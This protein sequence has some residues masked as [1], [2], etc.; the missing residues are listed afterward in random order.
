MNDT[1]I[2]KL[3]VL[4]NLRMKILPAISTEGKTV[5]DIDDLVSEVH[6]VMSEHVELI[7]NE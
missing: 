6:R 3:F 2:E 5:D 7:S 4:G 1:F